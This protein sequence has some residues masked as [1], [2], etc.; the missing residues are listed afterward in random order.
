M[1]LIIADREL[2]NPLKDN[3]CVMLAV[4]YINFRGEVD[5]LE[6]F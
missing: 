2:P 6:N 1:G 3:H 4:L 5:F